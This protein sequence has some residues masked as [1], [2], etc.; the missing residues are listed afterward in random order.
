MDVIKLCSSQSRGQLLILTWKSSI[1]QNYCQGFIFEGNVKFNMFPCMTSHFIL[2]QTH[3]PQHFIWPWP[4]KDESQG[5]SGND[6]I[7]WSIQHHSRGGT[8]C[9]G[10]RQVLVYSKKVLSR[11]FISIYWF[12]FVDRFNATP[13]AVT[14]INETPSRQSLT[15]P[16]RH[17]PPPRSL[18]LPQQ[19]FAF[20]F[21][22]MPK[23]DTIILTPSLQSMPFLSPP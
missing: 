8:G 10:R 13:C 15:A 9:G 18:T 19:L 7:T 22:I 14:E 16:L 2:F 20:L 11:K 3:A 6:S 17:D 1:F 12:S 4:L 21:T 5:K 23:A